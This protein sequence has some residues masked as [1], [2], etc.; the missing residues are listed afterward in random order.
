MSQLG[1][2][3]TQH[4]VSKFHSDGTG[5]V[6]LRIKT[7]IPLGVQQT[8]LLGVKHRKV[9]FVYRSKRVLI[10]S[11][12]EDDSLDQLV[13]LERVVGRAHRRP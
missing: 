2:V 10:F 13:Q 8:P 6:I 7:F 1:A 9:L 11:L 12:L 5:N 3:F 4:F